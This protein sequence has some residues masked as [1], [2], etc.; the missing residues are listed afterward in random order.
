MSIGV[1]LARAAVKAATAHCTALILKLFYIP[2]KSE[3]STR[4]VVV[5]QAKKFPI[6]QG[7][8]S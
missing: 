7:V 8:I 5:P 3:N 6:V 2:S 1:L 4:F